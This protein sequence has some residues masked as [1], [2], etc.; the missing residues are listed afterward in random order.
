MHRGKSRDE[1]NNILIAHMSPLHDLTV[2][3]ASRHKGRTKI[4]APRSINRAFHIEIRYTLSL[5]EISSYHIETSL[6]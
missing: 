2:S 5:C 4:L 1:P 3:Q 6:S